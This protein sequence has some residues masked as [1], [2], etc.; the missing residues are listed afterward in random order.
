MAM[1]LTEIERIQIREKTPA[2]ILM[3]GQ[4]C[5]RAAGTILRNSLAE[6]NVEI[7]ILGL[8][9]LDLALKQSKHRSTTYKEELK[10]KII[11]DWTTQSQTTAVSGVQ[12]SRSVVGIVFTKLMKSTGM[13]RRFLLQTLQERT[14]YYDDCIVMCRDSVEM[15]S[16]SPVEAACFSLKQIMMALARTHSTAA[17]VI[18]EKQFVTL[19]ET[20]MRDIAE[21][22]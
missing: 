3:H 5:R 22:L 7:D 15:K 2:L 10:R 1:E 17:P 18:D 20:F 13:G 4:F 12:Q 14:K 11:D 16:C 6:T 21:V 8:Y 9:L 19:G